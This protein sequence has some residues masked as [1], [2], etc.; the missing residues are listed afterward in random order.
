VLP[1]LP[2]GIPKISL[3]MSALTVGSSSLDCFSLISLSCD[4][5]P[6]QGSDFLLSLIL[7]FK[8]VRVSVGSVSMPR[9]SSILGPS[10]VKQSLPDPGKNGACLGENPPTYLMKKL[11]RRDDG[12]DDDVRREKSLSKQNFLSTP[13]PTLSKPEVP[14]SSFGGNAENSW[15]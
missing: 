8:A 1:K 12:G 7:F 14:N 15:W 5:K 11:W 6:P 3:L 4:L 2:K 10:W 13:T 9:I